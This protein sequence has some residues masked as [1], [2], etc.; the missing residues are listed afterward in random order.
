M[1]WGGWGFAGNW[2]IF[3]NIWGVEQMLLMMMMMMMMIHDD[4]WCWWWFM[5]HDPWWFMMI[6]HDFGIF[7]VSLFF[8]QKKNSPQNSQHGPTKNT[9]YTR[10]PRFPAKQSTAFSPGA[11]KA[12][13]LWFMTFTGVKISVKFRDFLCFFFNVQV[14][15]LQLL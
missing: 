4:S 3:S 11:L 10:F 15:C 5:I 9:R 8:P 12:P 13:G 6:S 1:H 2:D 14:F 7:L